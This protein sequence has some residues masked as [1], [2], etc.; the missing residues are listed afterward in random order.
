VRN[1]LAFEAAAVT[2]HGSDLF[3]GLEAALA[4]DGLA[5]TLTNGSA[6]R[7]LRY[8]LNTGGLQ[9]QFVSMTD[10]IVQAPVPPAQCAVSGLVELPFDNQHVLA[11]ERSFAVDVPG[12]GTR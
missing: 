7:N 11:I 8:N 1:N 12:T 4:Q 6:S 9:K 5:A 2:P 10:P 3:V